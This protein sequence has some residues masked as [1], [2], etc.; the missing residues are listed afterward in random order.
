MT[1]MS[2]PATKPKRFRTPQEEVEFRRLLAQMARRDFWCFIQLMFGVLHPNQPLVYAPY[3]ELL[4][5]LMMDVADGKRRRVIV[6]MPPRHM[7]SLICSVLYVAWRLGNNPSAKFITISY[8]DDLAH[9]HA[10]LTRKIMQSSKYRAI[11][12]GT[13]L[14]KKAV[15]YLRTT[16]GGY[17]YSTS[18]GSDITGFGADEI[19]VDDP[20]QPDEA[21][22]ESVKQKLRDWIES[23]VVTRFNNPS[24]GVLL[25]VMHRL[26]Q[27]DLAATLGPIADFV[28]KLPLIA[29]QTECITL[30]GFTFRRRPGDILNETRISREEAAKLEKGLASHIF[31]GLYQQRPK[32]GGSGMLSPGRFRRFDLN[33]PPPF[34]LLI[35]SWD[36]GATITGNASVCTKWGLARNT[37]G[38]DCLYLL[39]VIRLK[40]TLPD[41]EEMIMVEDRA[42]SPALIVLDER[43]V[44]MQMFQ[45]FGQEEKRHI[46]GSTATDGPVERADNAPLPSRSKI[47]RF[48]RATLWIADGLIFIPEKAEWLDDFLY[49]VVAFPNFSDDD[50][51]DSM[52]QVIANFERAIYLARR[53]IEWG[54]CRVPALVVPVEKGG[55]PRSRERARNGRRISVSDMKRRDEKLRLERA[56]ACRS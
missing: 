13:V 18:V 7:K 2:E 17:R 30:R 22:S 16:K 55:G 14:D 29:E 27:D 45:R 49:E 10:N 56:K 21:A 4:A 5:S 8:G 35:H 6:N 51:V 31:A 40:R 3:L 26:A 47:D 38:R 46:I 36:V 15:D 1:L 39:Q 52:C 19:I 12:P 42:D 41:I 28:L 53:N 50:Q 25:L 23:S 37:E 9:D 32:P 24:K 34:E 48:G 44:G 20:L 11:F 54:W 33:N 43:G